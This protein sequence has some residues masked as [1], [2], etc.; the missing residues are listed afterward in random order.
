MI[1]AHGPIGYLIA[2]G[3]KR[4]WGKHTFS[5]RQ[6]W[7]L[8]IVGAIGGMFPDVD[9]FYFYF[10][11]ASVAHR[12]LLTHS[13]LPYLFIIALGFV[14]LKIRQPWWGWLTLLFGLGGMSH[15]F[16]DMFVGLAAALAPFTNTVFGLLTI[17]GVGDS[18]FGRYSFVVN[19]FT[20]FVIIVVAIGTVVTNRRRFIYGAVGTVIAVSIL[21]FWINRHIYKPDGL[22]YFADPDHD[23]VVT[24]QD[25]DS[26]GDNFVTM[27][28]V[29]IDNDGEDNSL[30]FYYETFAAEGSLYDYSNGGFIEVPLRVGLVTDTVLI[31]R[32]YAN[33]GI[34]FGTEMTYNYTVQPEGYI[35]TPANNQFADS[36]ANWQTWLWHT[37]RLLDP[38]SW[39]NEFDILFFESGHVGVYMY[40]PNGENYVF[41]A[42]SSHIKTQAVPLENV[43]A[44]EGAVTSIGRILPK[45]Y[46]KRY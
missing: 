15:L 21:L 40:G 2:R 41:E 25:R 46:N 43:I 7:A 19:Y 35:G 17:P 34:F 13:I 4:W 26:D 37:N 33:V 10:V 39:M 27:I 6:Q 28:D 9:L 24:M 29:D 1:I 11:D 31:Q 23:G 18:W 3:T 20:E 5:R 32:L 14:L 45:P 8:F 12:Q 38:T 42:D 36:A 16:A 44:R 30:D 22:F